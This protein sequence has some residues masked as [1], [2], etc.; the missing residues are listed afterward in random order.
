[1][2]E[3]NKKDG[4]SRRNF[5]KG[6][7]T[8]VVGGY[9]APKV[10]ALNKVLPAEINE[11]DE[12]K[13]L[14]QFSVNGKKH[15]LEI[16]PSSTLAEVLRNDLELMGTKIVCNQ[17]ECGGCTVL[18]DKKA[19]YSCHMLAVEAEG[20]EVT[21][22]EG[23]GDGNDLHPVQQAFVDHDG[24]QCGFCTPGQIMAAEALL[25]EKPKPTRDEVL[26]AMSGNICRCSAYPKIIDSVLAA[27]EKNAKS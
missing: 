11:Y 10:N 24:L 26:D 21:T 22:I 17:G 16:F 3:K 6:V 18:L 12:R 2:A 20:K 7:G 1:M 14:L 8:G 15:R 23:L 4:I 19:V 5:L 25:I 9:L 13:V 27:A